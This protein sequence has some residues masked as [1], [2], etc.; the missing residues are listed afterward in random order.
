MVDSDLGLYGKCHGRHLKA[1][2]YIF[3][4]NCLIFKGCF[5]FHSNVLSLHYYLKTF[6]R[7]SWKET[8]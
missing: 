3:V 5:E 8:L 1:F 7:L 2:Y 4:E 6:K